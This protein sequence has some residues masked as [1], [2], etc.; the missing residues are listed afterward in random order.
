MRV[1]GAH[2]PIFLTSIRK[3]YSL[4]ILKSKYFFVII[5]LIYRF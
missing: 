3:K 5:L 1:I 4:N 2:S